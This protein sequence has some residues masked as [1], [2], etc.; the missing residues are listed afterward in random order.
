MARADEAFPGRT[1]GFPA[2]ASV[3]TVVLSTFLIEATGGSTKR[4]SI[5]TS[6]SFDPRALGA[7]RRARGPSAN[8]YCDI[9]WI[10]PALKQPAAGPHGDTD[11]HAARPA[12]APFGRTPILG[13]AAIK[14]RI[15][16][17]E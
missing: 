13:C 4:T 2:A 7:V 12:A 14:I 3:R 5:A 10:S 11:N 9:G 8:L 16:P 1:L 15:E 17:V 6:G